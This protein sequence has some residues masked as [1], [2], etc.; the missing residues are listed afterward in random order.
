LKEKK[1]Q[2]EAAAA[3]EDGS[4]EEGGVIAYIATWTD[5]I[6]YELPPGEPFIP[7]AWY[8]NLHKGT[9][10]LLI[11][12]MMTYY[13]NWSL[14]CWMYFALH[15]SY[16]VLWVMKDMTIPDKTFQRKCT[17][18]SAV[19]PYPTFLL[20]YC[21]AGYLMCSN[22]ANQNPSPERLAICVWMYIFGLVLMMGT[23]GQKYFM[24]R[25]RRG[26]IHDGF[27]KW[28][29]NMN[30]LGEMMIY[31]SFALEVGEM[32]PYYVLLYTQ[33][34]V[35][36]LRMLEKDQSLWKKDGG[37]EYFDRTWMLIPK[38]FNSLLL[39]IVVYGLAGYTI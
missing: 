25:E 33:G 9:M 23:D 37:K 19:L 29:R 24:L 4:E 13:D 36:T 11:L 27:N 34:F 7:Q 12:A 22:Q 32:G 1:R 38:I 30:Y 2:S 28:S 18:M 6:Y 26:L 14:G 10:P 21:L 15:G 35:F 39:S 16:G 3:K 17:L 5:W 31:G 8:V 20:P